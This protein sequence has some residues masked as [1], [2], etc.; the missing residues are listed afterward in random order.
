M[1]V[2]VVGAG[3]VGASVAV[4]L[5]QQGAKVTLL[6]QGSAGS[7]TTGTSYAWINSNG[8]EPPAYYRLNLGGLQAHTKLS[9]TDDSGW[10]GLGG[11]VEF[12]VD[13]HHRENLAARIKRL[14]SWG[15]SVNELTAEEAEKLLPDI[16]VP[17]NVQLIAHYTEEGYAYPEKYLA[18]MLG[19]ARN[20]GVDIR[21]GNAVTGLEHR[22]D[23]VTLRT[24][25]GGS[26]EIDKVVSAVGRWTRPFAALA[27]LNIPVLEFASPG[28]IVVGYLAITN[29]LPVR[30]SRLITSPWLNVRPAGGGRL[31]LQA[32]DLDT[33]ADPGNVP[34]PDSELAK[35]FLQRLRDVMANTEGAVIE[36]IHV[37]QRVMPE[38]GRTIA[39]PVPEAPWL[40]VIATHSGVTLAPYLGEVVAA[41]ILGEKQ[42]ALEEFRLERFLANHTFGKPYAP[43]KPGEQ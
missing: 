5:A 36:K 37:G 41:E 23:S 9:P 26:L 8:K 38:D 18:H 43:R 27:G 34:G 4:R 1:R 32:L 39:G 16:R 24:R 29:P 25:D 28:D 42:E 17:K 22:G 3:V 35:T 30:L 21:T 19:E 7:G 6:E 2:A 13:D 31:M 11:H 12:A 40:Y 33:T 10:L 20:A 15:Y 14:R